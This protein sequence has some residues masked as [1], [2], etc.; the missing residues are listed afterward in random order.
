MIDIDKV[1][2]EVREQVDALDVPQFVTVKLHDDN[3]ALVGGD[4][5]PQ[6]FDMVNQ[7][8]VHWVLPPKTEPIDVIRVSVWD[9]E[10]PLWICRLDRLDRLDTHMRAHAGAAVTLTSVDLPAIG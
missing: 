3:D 4:G 7:H 9:G 6:T 5:M 8:P 2:R 1:L 10:Q